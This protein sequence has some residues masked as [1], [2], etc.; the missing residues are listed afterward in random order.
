MDVLVALVVG[1]T[2][3]LAKRQEAIQQHV[4][5]GNAIPTNE[6]T[7]FDET[8]YQLELPSAAQA[9]VAEGLLVLREFA[10]F[11]R[12]GRPGAGSTVRLQALKGLKTP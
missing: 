1:L 7:A 10:G 3:G 11:A 2:D 8:V 6:L 9:S 4:C 5:E 12:P